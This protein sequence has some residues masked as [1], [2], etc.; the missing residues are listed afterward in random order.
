MTTL[1]LVKRVADGFLDA[2]QLAKERFS[3]LK[4]WL[5]SQEAL[6]S[7]LHIVECKQEPKGREVQRLMLQA[8]V[9]QRSLGEVGPDLK[10]LRESEEVLYTHRRVRKRCLKTIFGAISIARMG[11]SRRGEE[12]IY[13]LDEILQL[14]ARSFSLLINGMPIP[15]RSLE[16]VIKDAAF[17]II[18]LPGHYRVIKKIGGGHEYRLQGEWTK[19]SMSEV[20]MKRLEAKTAANVSYP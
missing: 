10:V 1:S 14:P 16:E 11:Y 6:Q 13:P 8:H 20:Q 7:P 9:E 4:A 19:R 15:K 3:E 2:M 17:M 18:K 5:S 12:S